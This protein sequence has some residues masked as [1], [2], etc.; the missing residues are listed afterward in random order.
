MLCIANLEQPEL[1]DPMMV[2][3]MLTALLSSVAVVTMAAAGNG[4]RT[5]AAVDVDRILFV[6]HVQ[7]SR[8]HQ[9]LTSSHSRFRRSGCRRLKFARHEAHESGN[10]TV[11]K[12]ITID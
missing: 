11:S 4:P 7:G 2:L 10:S 5:R 1:L 6:F 12:N 3:M 8:R 9:E